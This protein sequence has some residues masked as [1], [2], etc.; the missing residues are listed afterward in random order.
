MR[1]IT[2]RNL[3]ICLLATALIWSLGTLYS[4]LTE[5]LSIQPKDLHTDQVPQDPASP[6]PIPAVPISSVSQ[7]VD[8]PKNKETEVHISS[9]VSAKPIQTYEVTAYYLNVRANGYPKSKIINVVEKGTR[10]EI[11]AKTD[12]GWLRI[13]GGGYVHGDYAKLVDVQAVPGEGANQADPIQG[14]KEDEEERK[15]EEGSD[16]PAEP[17]QPTS[18]VETLSGLSEENI[19]VIFEGTALAGHGL[20]KTVL[21]VEED[22]GINA[23]F[24]IAVMKLESGNGSSTLAKKKN[25]LFGLNASGANPHDKAYSFETKGDS[26]RKFGQLL[27]NNYVDKGYT[28]IEKIAGKYCPANSQWPKLVKNIMKKDFRKLNVI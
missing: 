14:G 17:V 20:E 21:E 13:K 26:V 1:R 6:P 22:Y 2:I 25:N 5:A 11:V 4:S 24:T 3:M 23:L 27:S 28:T 12:N 10:L 19:A 8:I 18:T 16:K 9:S 7:T 15:A